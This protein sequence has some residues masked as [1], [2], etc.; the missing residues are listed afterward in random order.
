MKAVGE[1]EAVTIRVTGHQWWWEFEYEDSIPARRVT[2]ANEIHLPVG[3][4]VGPPE[5]PAPLV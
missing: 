1:E 2:T 5:L 4:V 3:R